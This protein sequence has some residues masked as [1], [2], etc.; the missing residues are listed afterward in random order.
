MTGKTCL[1]CDWQGETSEPGCPNCGIQPLYVVGASPSEV[2]RT[3]ARND[4]EARSLETPST[5][6]MAPSGTTSPRS[7]PSP[8]PADTSASVS[9]SARS[10]VAFVLAALVLTVTLGTWLKSHEERPA[11]AASS[12]A[13]VLETPASDGLPAPV[14]APSPTTTS[15]GSPKGLRVAR[16][17]L[18][19]EGVPL[20]FDVPTRGWAQYGDLSIS[21]STVGP[22]GAEAIVF[23][24]SVADGVFA[25]A[26][27]QWWGS[28]VGSVEDWAAQAARAHGTELVT[29][30]SSVTIDGYAAQH[31][32][33]TVRKDVACNPGFFHTWKPVD[34]GPFWSSTLVGDTIRIWLVEVGGKVLYIE[35]DTHEYADHDLEQEVER[36]VGSIRFG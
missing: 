18:T 10:A 3:P 32:V 28:P 2:V 20:S 12:D 4:P 14:D 16:H 23:W 13:A 26:C 7:T 31:V 36:I 22:Q 19:V 15:V 6:T 9:R 27:G 21:K 34:G 33:F 5:A 35:G 1:R 30:P 17:S 24:T 8:S 25:K 11:S 29:G